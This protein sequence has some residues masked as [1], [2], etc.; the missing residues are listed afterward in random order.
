MTFLHRVQSEKNEFFIANYLLAFI[1]ILT[2]Q[3]D[4]M[5]IPGRRFSSQS[6]SLCTVL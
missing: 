4:P 6:Q 5:F 2:E 3:S 1:L